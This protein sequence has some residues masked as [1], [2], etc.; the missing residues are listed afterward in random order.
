MMAHELHRPTFTQIL[1]RL[2]EGMGV[3]TDHV[4]TKSQKDVGDSSL[5]DIDRKI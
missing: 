2:D 5:G 4:P 1:E 3:D